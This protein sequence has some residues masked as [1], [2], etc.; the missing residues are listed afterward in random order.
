[1]YVPPDKLDIEAVFAPLFQRYE[2]AP[3]PPLTLVLA[4]PSALPAHDTES[5]D[6]VADNGAG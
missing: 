3:F 2:Y 6:V 1:M 4:I 5:V